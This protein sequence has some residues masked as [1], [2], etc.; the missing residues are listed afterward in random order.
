MKERK[1]EERERERERKRAVSS[2]R[3]LYM[4]YEYTGQIVNIKKN[5]Q[6]K[7]KKGSKSR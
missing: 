6:T 4:I 5:L 2:L 7:R 1:K 3:A